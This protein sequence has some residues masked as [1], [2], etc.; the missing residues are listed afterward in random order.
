MIVPVVNCVSEIVDFLPNVWRLA[1]KL[2]L[3][4]L[5]GKV[6]EFIQIYSVSSERYKSPCIQSFF[7]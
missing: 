4:R 3:I 2:L 5:A 7:G 1:S 6:Q